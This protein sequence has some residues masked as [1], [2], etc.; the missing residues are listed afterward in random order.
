MGLTQPYFVFL[1]FLIAQS[2]Q[3]KPEP[4]ALICNHL[5]YKTYRVS[6]KRKKT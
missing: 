3:F 4:V 2:S 6:Q 5:L 1:G